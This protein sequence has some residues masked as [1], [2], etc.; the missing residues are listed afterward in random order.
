MRLTLL[1]FL[2]AVSATFGQS[3]EIRGIAPGYVGERIEILG[4]E[5]YFS[6][7]ERLIT[8]ATV[9]ADS[10]FYFR[11]ESLQTQ[12]II[13]KSKNN[14]GYLFVQPN[15]NYT[16]F[17]PEK[18]KFTPSLPSG[19]EVELAFFELD[20]TDINYKILGFQ[21]W[22][23]HFIGNYYHL[24]NVDAIKFVE[25]LDRFKGNVEKAY[26]DD[27][28]TYFKVH[29]RY[30]IAGL[31]NINHAAE[32]NRYEKYDFYLK[33]M[34]VQYHNEAYMLYVADFYQKL[35]PRLSNETNQAVFD[36]V[37]KSSPTLVMKAL[38]T[39]YTLSN[40]RM[41]ELIMI[42]MLSEAYSMDDF[43]KTNV[44]TILDSLSNRT[45]FKEHSAIAKNMTDRI[46]ALVPGGEAP[47]LVLVQE[48]KPTKTLY[49]FSGKHLYLHFF[50]PHSERC[51]LELPLLKA[52]YEKYH[53]YVHFVSVYQ[54]KKELTEAERT[55]LSTITWDLY[56]VP[57]SN[58]IWKNYAVKA[59]PHY[60]LI[61]AAG[62]I[63]AS[64]S[65]APT[66]N[67]QYETIDRT[68][69]Y[70]RQAHEKERNR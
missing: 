30:T 1:L 28:S 53:P 70:L 20:S 16:L 27:T 36:A 45:F 18:D 23:D 4:I 50:D 58:P 33:K 15:S 44:L 31:D 52:M 68:F 42:K 56:E 29:V 59:V 26:M 8:T 37:L 13:L 41:R 46:T 32:R 63:V 40:L 65:L 67:G 6:F 11:F 21:R 57:T 61:D 10:S 25:A 2:F 39:E 51:M 49:D 62:Y 14:K 66:P 12:K 64:P 24:K 5:D 54:Q 22:V 48:G 43:P 47:P 34:P 19:N 3:V 7:Q 55:A 17:F 9:E 60:S 38:A 69:F 35:I